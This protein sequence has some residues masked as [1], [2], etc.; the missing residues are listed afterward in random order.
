MRGRA[1]VIAALPLIACG[2]RHDRADAL[3]ARAWNEELYRSDLRAVIPLDASKPDSA[4]LAQRFIDNWAHERV[5]LHK[6][7]ANLSDAQKNV[8]Q[9]LAAYRNSL[10]IY[11]YE[12]ALIE[13]KLDTNVSAVDIEKYYND[14]IKNFELKD[15]IVRVRWFKLHEHDKRI[16]KKVEDQWRSDNEQETHQLEVF[17][18]QRGSTINDTHEDW[19]AFSELEQLV[20]IAPENP[21]DW[22]PRQTKVIAEDSASTYFID[23]VEHRLKDSTSPLPLVR[24]NIRSIL[25]NQRKL[26]LVE[27]MREDLYNE[28]IA[29]KEVRVF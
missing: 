12:Q 1:A 5:V 29:K 27:R 25:I 10:I 9:Q 19:I 15:N 16:L 26:Q 22:I 6:A 11:A 3:V 4:A 18:A 2:A 28:A 20:P 17:L 8:E 23:F 21:T 7:E 13:Q 14:N 24:A